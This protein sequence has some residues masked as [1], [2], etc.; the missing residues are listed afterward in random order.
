MVDEFEFFRKVQTY[1]QHVPFNV[2]FTYRVLHKTHKTAQ[3]LG[4]F[5]CRVDPHQQIVEYN[6]SLESDYISRPFSEKVSFLFPSQ[7]A[8]IPPQRIVIDQVPIYQLSYPVPI[9]YDWKTF[10]IEGANEAISPN[11]L[12]PIFDKYK[13]TGK[14]GE[15]VDAMLKVARVTIDWYNVQG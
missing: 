2:E 11:R 4:Q 13:L 3:A 7:Y 5:C 8:E 6:I 14:D 10:I 12:Q 9:L 15:S 1:Y